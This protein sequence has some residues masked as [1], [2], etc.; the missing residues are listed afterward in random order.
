MKQ[1]EVFR[2]K[3]ETRRIKSRQEGK[4]GTYKKFSRNGVVSMTPKQWKDGLEML[5]RLAKERDDEWRKIIP[6]RPQ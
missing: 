5:I 2:Q 4:A 3:D 6:T 1:K